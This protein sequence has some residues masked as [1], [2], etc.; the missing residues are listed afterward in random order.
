[1][2][3]EIKMFKVLRGYDKS[4]LKSL[5]SFIPWDMLNEEQAQRNHSQTLNRLNERGGLCVTEILANIHHQRDR[6]WT[7]TQQT[8]DELNGLI[9]AWYLN[10]K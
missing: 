2:K 5:P 4:E 7:V 9:E 3:E 10:N 8:V 6:N 1:M